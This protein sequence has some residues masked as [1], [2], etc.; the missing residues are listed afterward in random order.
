MRHDAVIKEKAKEMY[1]T[2]GLNVSTIS[3]LL[4]EV[5]KRTLSAWRKEGNWEMLR[6]NKVAH[7]VIRREK[8]ERAL[9]SALDS[10]EA[11]FDPK[12]VRS[13]GELAAI[14]KSTLIFEFTEELKQNL[15]KR[16]KGLTPEALKE[17]EEKLGIF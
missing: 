8:I 4:H 2:N 13:I 5:T 17:I 14:L 7:T 16:K 11:N 15:N 6:K 12:L 1:V 3:S 9:D 10:L